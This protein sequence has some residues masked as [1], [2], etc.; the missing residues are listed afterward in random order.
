MRLLSAISILF[1]CRASRI[2]VYFGPGGG[3]KRYTKFKVLLL[4]LF[5]A[6]PAPAL[7]SEGLEM[8][9]ELKHEVP[10]AGLSGFNL[11]VAETYNNNLV[12]YAVYCTVAMAVLGVVI[13]YVTD[14]I[15]SALGMEVHKIEH[16]E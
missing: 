2:Y 15:L 14:I 12:L 3:M 6:L 8:P 4:H 7:A 16:K 10:L 5:L 9:E 13:A 1:I 11:F